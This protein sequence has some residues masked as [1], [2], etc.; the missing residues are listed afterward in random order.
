MY[1]FS[2]IGHV[3]NFSQVSF[4]VFCELRHED[5]FWIDVFDLCCNQHPGVNHPGASKRILDPAKAGIPPSLSE[6]RNLL[7]ES[8][9]TQS[10][11]T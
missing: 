10:P 9:T 1:L 7:S 8:R 2:A 3:L 5:K 4:V 6:G 11:C